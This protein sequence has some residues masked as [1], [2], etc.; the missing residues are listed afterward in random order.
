MKLETFGYIL[1]TLAMLGFFSEAIYSMVLINKK[2]KLS[3]NDFT[4]QVFT[5]TIISLVL[6]GIG[7]FLILRE[8]M[9]SGIDTTGYIYLIVLMSAGSI[10]VSNVAILLSNYVLYWKAN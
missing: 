8:T 5:P 6:F 2:Q 10:F 3:P 9:K 1:N 4:L 7:S